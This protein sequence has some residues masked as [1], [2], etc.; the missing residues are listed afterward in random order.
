V[1][2]QPEEAK[3]ALEKEILELQA[4]VAKLEN[5]QLGEHLKKGDFSISQLI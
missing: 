1:F 2:F 5:D 3:K 4:T